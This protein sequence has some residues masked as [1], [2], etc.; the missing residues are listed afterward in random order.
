MSNLQTKSCLIVTIETN[1]QEVSGWTT[2]SNIMK[3]KISCIP[4]DSS[5]RY[6]SWKYKFDIKW[7][8]RNMFNPIFERRATFDTPKYPQGPW[9]Q[10]VAPNSKYIGAECSPTESRWPPVVEQS[11]DLKTPMVTGSPT[12][13]SGRVGHL[14]LFCWCRSFAMCICT[15]IHGSV[16]FPVLL[17]IDIENLHHY[18]DVVYQ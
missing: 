13:N 7:S 17:P 3:K 4:W 5:M 9:H 2:A 12:V 11:S 18:W 10:Y 1:I 14:W 16:A 8:N 6:P 15:N